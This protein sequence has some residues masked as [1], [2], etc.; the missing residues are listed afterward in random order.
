M[1]EIASTKD[2]KV[3]L[4]LKSGETVDAH[5][6]SF[7]SE[8]DGIIYEAIS[9]MAKDPEIRMNAVTANSM[10]RNFESNSKIGAGS[11]IHGF[12]DAYRYGKYGFPESELE[13]GVFTSMLSPE[14]RKMAYV[15]G[16]EFGKATVESAQSAIKPKS[17]ATEVSKGRVHYDGVDTKTNFSKLQK[18]SIKGIE[19]L[20]EAL[21]MDIY[22]YESKLVSGRRV[23][24]NGWFDYSDNSI[25]IDV[26][27]GF[28]GKGTM[29]NTAAHELTHVIKK[30]SPAKFQAF[31][32]FLF[33]QYGKKGVS[34][35]SLVR[36][37]IEKA[38]RNGREIDY[39]TAYE[40]VV[41][42]SCETFLSDGEA[43]RK[44][45]ELDNSLWQKI[46]S[47]IALI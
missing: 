5:D 6:I 38:K 34:V 42:D 19:V 22:L 47:F 39:E 35:D 14:T 20:A 44:L 40:E 36:A 27:A 45:A 9:D 17:K 16:R 18:S 3:T 23:G 25:H 30:W 26:Y 4:R 33:E 24:A 2:G 29:L 37:Q 41:A 7:A 43:I 13:K 10:L 8:N 15:Q 32:E 1:K 31:A 28:D 11:Y 46:K 12:K 21:G